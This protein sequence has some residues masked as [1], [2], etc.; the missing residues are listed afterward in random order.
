MKRA[1]CKLSIASSQGAWWD[2]IPDIL[3]AMRTT[4]S[5]TGISPYLLIFK[6]RP[7]I[8]LDEAMAWGEDVNPEAS[9]EATIWEDE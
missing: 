9:P 4:P 2:F 5:A 6:H 1:L 8:P 7:L 3:R